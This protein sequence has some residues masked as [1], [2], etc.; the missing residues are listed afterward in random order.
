MVTASWYKR[1][2]ENIRTYERNERGAVAKQDWLDKADRFDLNRVFWNRFSSFRQQILSNVLLHTWP[3]WPEAMHRHYIIMWS[4]L[5]VNTVK[6]ISCGHFIS[7]IQSQIKWI[8]IYLS[9]SLN[10]TCV[11]HFVHYRKENS[12]NGYLWKRDVSG[13]QFRQQFRPGSNFGLS[14]LKWSISIKFLV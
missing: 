9:A 4:R 13:Q 10:W 2:Y 7:Q 6:Q 14:H 11:W 3:R 8:A 5:V 1:T 12:Y